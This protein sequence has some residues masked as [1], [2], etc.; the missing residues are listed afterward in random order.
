MRGLLAAAGVSAVLLLA[1][2]SAKASDDGKEAIEPPED[3][4]VYEMAPL[5]DFAYSCGAHDCR[6]D[7]FLRRAGVCALLVLKGDQ[8]FARY[9][10]DEFACSEQNEPGLPNYRR[11]RYG[12]A[13]VTKS[14]TSTLLGFALMKDPTDP[15]KGI[16][17]SKLQEPISGL[18]PEFSAAQSKGAYA[19]VPVER[20]LL[21][22]S[23]ASYAEYGADSGRLRN[24]VFRDR[25]ITSRD[26]LRKLRR[27]WD[28]PGGTV[29]PGDGAFNYAGADTQLLGLLTEKLSGEKLISYARKKLWVP[30]AMTTRAKWLLDSD[31]TAS[32]YCCFAATA[33]DLL[34]FGQFV[35][36]RGAFYGAQLLPAEWFDRATQ[37]AS[38]NDDLIPPGNASHNEKCPGVAPTQ[39]RYQ[40]W[41][42]PGRRD[43]TAIGINGQ[44]IHIYPE[45][46]LVIVQ[47]SSWPRWSDALEC[48]SLV[49]HDAIAR[50]FSN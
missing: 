1:P 40:W 5:P 33:P 38:P 8:A 22:R 21:M 29:G 7:E 6:R 18:L 14:I 17:W 13:S 16:D 49:A 50:M 24:Q 46:D 45:K 3:P 36:D 12:I 2:T 34:R 35:R 26:F 44:F 9:N 28:F 30:L 25:S 11:Q 32:A 20:V 42:F 31:R 43:F 4:L 19:G 23:G 48:E 10:P 41:L 15:A 27:E 37:A 47:I 39:Y